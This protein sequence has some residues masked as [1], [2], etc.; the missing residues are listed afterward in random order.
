MSKQKQL[1][2]ST[3]GFTMIE[4]LV[5]ATIMIVLTGVGLVSYRIASMNVRNSKRKADQQTIRSALV[6]YKT[7]SSDGL[8]PV[9]NVY[10]EMIAILVAAGYFDQSDL[11]DP[12]WETKGVTYGYETLDGGR[13]FKLCISIEPDYT[14]ECLYSP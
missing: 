9:T 4:M 5:V 2:S 10:F 13:D 6:L 12:Q 14:I 8:Y 1:L 3:S 7:D 11:N